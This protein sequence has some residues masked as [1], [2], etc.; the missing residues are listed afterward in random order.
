[1]KSSINISSKKICSELSNDL[2]SIYSASDQKNIPPFMKLF[3][4]EQQKYLSCSNLTSIRYH[5][6]IIKYCLNLASKS[7]SAYSDLRYDPQTG[8]GILTLPSLR[9]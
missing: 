5:P 1:M 3:W 6:A 2:I 7:P 9:T 8:V 4:E